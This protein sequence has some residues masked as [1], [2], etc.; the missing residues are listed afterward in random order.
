MSQ[1]CEFIAIKTSE[2]CTKMVDNKHGFCKRHE[3]TI[4]ASKKQLSMEQSKKQNTH[5][6]RQLTVDINQYGNFEEKETHLVFDPV[7]KEVIGKQAP[8][9]ATV[10]DLTA[11]D[12]AICL[13]RR[14]NYVVYEKPASSESAEWDE[15]EASD[16]SASEEASDAEE[17]EASAEDEA[18]ASEEASTD[19]EEAEEVEASE[20]EEASAEDASEEEEEASDEEDDSNSE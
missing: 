11:Q 3:N 20:E 1:Q 9:K 10:L 6:V 12:I 8:G 14:W 16:A 13:T 2:R 19:E 17:E 7:T 4:Q 5:K 15:A 18:S